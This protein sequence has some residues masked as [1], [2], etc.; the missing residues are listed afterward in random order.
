MVTVQ[1]GHLVTPAVSEYFRNDADSQKMF[2]NNPLIAK[3][4]LFLIS[5]PQAKII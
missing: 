5:L 2:V 3:A 1:L 4:T